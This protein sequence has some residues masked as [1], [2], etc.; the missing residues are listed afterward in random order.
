MTRLPATVPPADLPGDGVPI[1]PAATVLIVDDRPDLQVVMMRRSATSSFVADHT[2][3]P[4]GRVEDSDSDPAWGPV[5]LGHDE[6]GKGLVPGSDGDGHGHRVAAARETL[7]EVGLLIGTGADQLLERRAGVERGEVGF[8]DAVIEAGGGLDVSRIVPVARW[9]TPPGSNRR[10]DTYFFVARPGTRVEPVA[11]GREAVEVGWV[12]PAEALDRWDSG[13]L[14]MISPTISMLQLLSGFTSAADVLDA[15]SRGAE[16][17]QARVL[18]DPPHGPGAS[19]VWWPGDAGYD[20]AATVATMGWMWISQ[21]PAVE[22][23]V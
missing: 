16:P 14:T 10:Y 1:W 22:S 7:E 4:G 19:W 15:A 9:V 11:D 5:L 13:E 12:R 6:G 2:V 3:F 17:V 20:T 18:V 21:P 23:T 8:V